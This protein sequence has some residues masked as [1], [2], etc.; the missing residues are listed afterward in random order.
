MRG[1]LRD[2]SRDFGDFMIWYTGSKRSTSMLVYHFHDHYEIYYQLS[3][4]R[5]FFI[6]NGNYYL[7]KG[8]IALVDSNVIHRTT[9]YGEQGCERVLVNIQKSFLNILDE[10]VRRI[11]VPSCFR[12]GGRVLRLNTEQQLK[13]ESL[14]ENLLNIDI[15][16][17]RLQKTYAQTLVIQ[18]L[19]LLHMYVQDK[20]LHAARYSDPYSEKMS[21]IISYINRNYMNPI[22]LSSLAKEFHMSISSLT[23][24]FKRVTGYTFT[25]YLNCVRVK[26]AQ[27]LLASENLSVTQLSERVGYSSINHFCR[28][29][30]RI[31]GCSAL[32]FKKAL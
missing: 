19:I 32:E 17:Y 24:A 11:I 8:D 27:K 16:D 12:E 5:R 25:Q 3:G 22:T 23:R 18:L 1:L 6:G 13:V 30:K 7:K 20:S 28:M 10:D 15:D 26:E 14:L 31:S 29:F 4:E 21:T 9:A 2:L